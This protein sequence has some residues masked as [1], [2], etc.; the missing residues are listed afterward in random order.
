MK[1]QSTTEEPAATTTQQ[2]S[3]QEATLPDNDT[4]NVVEP[5]K[6]ETEATIT[7]SDSGFSPANTTVK[8]GS[9]VTFV[10]NSSKEVQP[11][12]D[13]HPIHTAN[14]ELNAGSI[15]AGSSKTVTLTKTGSWGYHNHLS[16]GQRGTIMV[17]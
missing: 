9:K 12:S 10:N 6:T 3:G 14:P 13:P 8:A 11:A 7:F 15:A 1:D 5:E 16:S 2:T 17:E 4:E